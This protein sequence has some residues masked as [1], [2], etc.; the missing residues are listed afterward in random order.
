MNDET[1]TN[2]E[3]APVEEGAE[4]QTLTEEDV[5]KLEDLGFGGGAAD[6]SIGGA[7]AASAEGPE[8]PDTEPDDGPSIATPEP[9][10]QD[11]GDGGQQIPDIC[12]CGGRWTHHKLCEHYVQS[13]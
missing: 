12:A 7:Q 4:Q 1:E 2:T 13:A 10:Q 3:E 11:L 9:E 6:G 8:P 5:G